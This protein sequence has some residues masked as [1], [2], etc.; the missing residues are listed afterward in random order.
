MTDLNGII[1]RVESGS[2]QDTVIDGDVWCE[3]FAPDAVVI[4]PGVQ[5]PPYT[6]SLDAVLALIEAK[7]PGWA[8]NTQWVG[9]ELCTASARVWI[10]SIRT[11]GLKEE[12][13]QCRNAQSAERALL[14]AALRAIA[15]TAPQ[16]ESK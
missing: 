7:L 3:I 14:A 2:G 13:F 6:S 5:F 4:D 15:S 1:E 10:P 8:W 9:V 16:Q 12:D 11:Q